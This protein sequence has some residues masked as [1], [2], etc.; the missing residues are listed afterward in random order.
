MPVQS[1]AE[2]L[3]HLRNGRKFD[4]GI[5][6]MQMPDMDGIELAL[7]IRSLAISKDMPLIMLSSVGKPEQ[8]QQE[9]ETAHFQVFLSK[10]VKQFRLYKA[11]VEALGT[12]ETEVNLKVTQKT[13]KID[14]DLG[15]RHP[16]RILIAED[17]PVNQKLAIR[18]LEKNGI[19]C[20]RRRQWA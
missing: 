13:S 20:R 10:P 11:F 4:L 19:S 16:L 14:H 6:D 18:V 15:N 5:L 2:A 9:L 7:A 12:S 1:G 8:R 17:N 3:D